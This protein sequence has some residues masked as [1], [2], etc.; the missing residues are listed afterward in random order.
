RLNFNGA[1]DTLFDT[2]SGAD[3]TVHSIAETFSGTNRLVLIAGAF[4][5]VNGVPRS[6]IARLRGENG[7]VDSAFDPGSGANGV[8][9]AVAA[10][11]SDGLFAG[12]CLV[13]GDFTTINGTACPHIARLNS[14]GSVDQGF[15]P[16]TGANDSV[17][18]INIQVD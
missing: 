12:K 10:Y 15:T 1:V 8:V 7:S 16:G 18:A 3:G 17:R 6:H 5:N 13:G 11:P 14:D 9:Y 4:N 2:G